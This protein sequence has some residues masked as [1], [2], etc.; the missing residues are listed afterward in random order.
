[1]RAKPAVSPDPGNAIEM[2]GVAMSEITVDLVG[3]AVAVEKP[4]EVVR[5]GTLRTPRTVSLIHSTSTLSFRLTPWI[6]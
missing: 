4:W 5:S 3:D 6:R 2:G 1:M